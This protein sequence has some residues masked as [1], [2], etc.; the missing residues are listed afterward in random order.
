MFLFLYAPYLLINFKFKI[1]YNG[2]EEE[3]SFKTV[4]F[5]SNTFGW[6]CSLSVPAII[7]FYF[8]WFRFK[9]GFANFWGR[10]KLKLSGSFEFGEISGKLSSFDTYFESGFN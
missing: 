7:D 3:I 5:K 10:L 4:L 2:V 1:L 6:I 9:G 8:F